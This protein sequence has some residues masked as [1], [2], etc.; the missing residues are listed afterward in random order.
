MSVPLS[1]KALRLECLKYAIASYS[2][3]KDGSP[4]LNRTDTII[5][6]SSVFYRWVTTDVELNDDDNWRDPEANRPPVRR[7]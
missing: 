3:I 5:E 7:T 4:R 6:M 1:N 2:Q